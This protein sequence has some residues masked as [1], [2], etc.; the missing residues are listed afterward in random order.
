MVLAIG[1]QKTLGKLRFLAMGRHQAVRLRT[2]GLMVG[3]AIRS[4]ILGALASGDTTL[5]KIKLPLRES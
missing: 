5:W 3:G 1:A 2:L 4:L